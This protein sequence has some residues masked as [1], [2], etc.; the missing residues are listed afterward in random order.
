M[1]KSHGGRAMFGS[2]FGVIAAAVGSAVGL[3]N[4]WRFPYEAGTHGGGAFL[5]CY[6]IAILVLGIP[7]ICAEYALGRA[8]RANIFGTYRKFSNS[9]RWN[10]AGC[11][12][13]LASI[14]ILSFYSVV[15]GW[16]LEYFFRSI[17]NSFAGMTAEDYHSEF[18]SF[19][20]SN[21]RPLLC[22]LLFLG[23]NYAVMRRG[24]TA[25]IERISKLLMPILFVILIVFCINS[26]MMDKAQEGLAF[27]FRPDFTQITPSVMLSALGQAFFSLSIGLGCM[28]IYGSYIKADANLTKMATVTVALDTLVAILAGVVIFPAVFTFGF[29]PAAGPAL[30]FEVLP[31]IF[32]QLP[33]GVIWSALFFLLLFVAS[34]TSTIS[35]SEDFIAYCTEERGMSRRSATNLNLGIAVVLGSLCTISFGCLNDFKIFGLTIFELFDYVASNILLPIGGIAV[36]IFAGWIVK[37][38]VMK[39]QLGVSGIV[40]KPLMICLR[41]IAPI[42]IL[43]VFLR[44]IGI[45]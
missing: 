6:I 2:K 24:V 23:I 20:T 26:L 8:G 28:M 37:K 21:W 3:G 15:A 32:N 7:T 34:L 19:S 11:L 9:N 1:A 18:V 36:T 14:M 27:L 42:S 30:V 12:G 38:S 22:T 13:I 43:L 44:S 10:W 40:F 39:Q 5:L 16:T 29:S 41:Y 4:I 31:A 45:I 35:M 33:G 17:S 25:G